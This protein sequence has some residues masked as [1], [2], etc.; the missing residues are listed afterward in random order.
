MFVVLFLLLARAGGAQEN[1]ILER[2]DPA[3]FRVRVNMRIRFELPKKD[4][5]SARGRR[6][7]RPDAMA[8]NLP[9]PES[10]DYQEIHFFGDLPGEVRQYPETG[11]KYLHIELDRHSDFPAQ[12]RIFDY[13]Y[14]FKATLYE[15]RTIFSRVLEFYPYR[16]DVT[17]TAYKGR[18]GDYIIPDASGIITMI[19][20]FQDGAENNLD[21]A[22][23][24]FTYVTDNFACD[25]V[26]W[27]VRP[28][29]EVIREKRGSPAGLSSVFISMLRFRGIPARHVAAVDL[30]GKAHTFAE[31]FLETYGWVPVDVGRAILAN[32]KRYFGNTRRSDRLIVMARD[33]NLTVKTLSRFGHP[34]ERKLASL[35]HGF[36]DAAGGSKLSYEFTVS[37][38]E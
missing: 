6:V 2:L 17:R 36:I 14:E 27:R 21:F 31:F 20:Q 3:T 4:S 8:V 7:I 12:K 25:K 38:I 1:K 18:N 28:L 9:L 30:D 33:I 34:G 32:D 10:N 13:G 11:E 24:A 22:K 16:D 23:R 5:T 19:E 29:E 35:Q 37:K 15:T 26:A